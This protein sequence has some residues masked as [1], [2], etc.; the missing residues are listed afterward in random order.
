MGSIDVRLLRKNRRWELNDR[1]LFSSAC[2]IDLTMLL[3]GPI[4]PQDVH[5]T[6]TNDFKGML[7]H[8]SLF[9][10]TYSLSLKCIFRNREVA[11]GVP[12]IAVR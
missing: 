7:F 1:E 11:Y 10:I 4:D 8:F 3:S 9:L 5:Q 6:C 12:F 2:L